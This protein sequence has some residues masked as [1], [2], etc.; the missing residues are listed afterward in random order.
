MR[1]VVL[2]PL[3]RS[4]MACVLKESHSFTCTPHVHPLTETIIPAFSFGLPGTAGQAKAG[5]A[6]S[7]SG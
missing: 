2:T 1:L 4:G 6:H 3:R 7:V 5:M